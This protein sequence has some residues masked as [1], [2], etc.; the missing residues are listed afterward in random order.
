M[1][2]MLHLI[3]QNEYHSLYSLEPDTVI[4]FGISVIYYELTSIKGKE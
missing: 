4:V 2:S 1:P 3:G